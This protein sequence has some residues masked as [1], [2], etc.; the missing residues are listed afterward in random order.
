[1]ATQPPMSAKPCFFV[2][3]CVPAE[4]MV[5]SD[6]GAK[7]SPK[8]E[9]LTMAPARTPGSHPNNTPAG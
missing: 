4:V 2:Y 3:S 7:L 9:A 6:I 1:M 5:V 8:I